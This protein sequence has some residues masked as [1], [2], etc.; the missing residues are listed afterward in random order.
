[1]FNLFRF[2]VLFFTRL[3][4]M[5]IMS[6]KKRQITDPFAY[7]LDHYMRIERMTNDELGTAVGY[8][9]GNMISAIRLGK[10]SGS[11]SRRRAIA[12]KFGFSLDGF[13]KEGERLMALPPRPA[14]KP[15][16]TG[17]NNITTIS[18]HQK[19]VTRFQ[20]PQLGKEINE[21]LL[22]IETLDPEVLD[23]IAFTLQKK[24]E[25][26]KEKH[27]RK[28]PGPQEKSSES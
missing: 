15:N 12:K 4:Y 1:M 20:N 3:V 6:L 14:E 10:T 19:L 24:L 23:E 21:T 27:T 28:R 9:N 22:K 18:E 25:Y 2:F 7:A 26:L 16:N 8:K 17:N 13:I 11:E 5:K